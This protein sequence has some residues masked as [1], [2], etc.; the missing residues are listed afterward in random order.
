MSDYLVEQIAATPRI[1]VR[2]GTE[3]VDVGDD[4][5]LRHLTVR[6]RESAVEHVL[7]AEALFVLIGARPHSDWL[8]GVVARDER[9]FLFTGP[10]AGRS[11]LF[12]TSVPGVFAI[13]DVRHG[14]VKRVA[15]S[16]GEGAIAVQQ[17]HGYLGDVSAG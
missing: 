13:G 7:R 10:E 4:H 12:E 5:R 11:L 16:V 3:I 9:G 1:D 15:S 14:S 2:L 17:L 6:E 8:D